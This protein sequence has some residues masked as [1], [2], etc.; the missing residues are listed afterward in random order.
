MLRRHIWWLAPLA[1]AA[2]RR[3]GRRSRVARRRLVLAQ[4]AADESRAPSSPRRRRSHSSGR[5]GR[6]ARALAVGRPD[7]EPRRARLRR[8][9]RH[10]RRHRHEQPRRRRRRPV[11]RHGRRA[12][13]R[14]LARRPF[15]AGRPG[16]SSRISGAKLTPAAFADSSKLDVGDFAI[17]IGNPLGLRSSVTDGIVS[18]FRQGVSE[19]N[20]VALPAD[21]P[22]E[23]GDQ[24]GQLRR[25]ARR[26]RRAA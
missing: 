24:P 14:R 15:R 19:G 7:P 21:D 8:R 22:D 9:V 26:P 20:G 16:Q 18:A 1:G 3:S 5:H 17:A 4:A 13:L 6:R 25:R 2:D 10:E 12:L 23:R 11:H